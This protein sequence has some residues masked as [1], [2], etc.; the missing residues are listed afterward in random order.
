LYRQFI[1]SYCKIGIKY[2][3]YC[4]EA[5]EINPMFNGYDGA[6]GSN[7]SPPRSMSMLAILKA[8]VA[9]R[10]MT[11]NIHANRMAR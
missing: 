2:S 6:Q 3:N 7:S 8:L 10:V 5:K 9:G 11:S 4:T 1:Y